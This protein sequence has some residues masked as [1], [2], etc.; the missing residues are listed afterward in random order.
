M[1]D[2]T[3]PSVARRLLGELIGIA[4][5]NLIQSRKGVVGATVSRAAAFGGQNVWRSDLTPAASLVHAGAPC[6]MD[7]NCIP[8]PDLSSKAIP[9]FPKRQ[10]EVVNL[11]ATRANGKQDAKRASTC[12]F[13]RTLHHESSLSSAECRR[14]E[15]NPQVLANNGF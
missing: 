4:V 5:P 2:I 6:F 8:F 11:K 1:A 12:S 14:W 7:L 13:L 3:I 10:N 15:S 9:E